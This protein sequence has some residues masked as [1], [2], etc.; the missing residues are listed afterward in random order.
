[1]QKSNQKQGKKITKTEFSAAID[2]VFDGIK[3]REDAIKFFQEI[4]TLDKNEKLTKNY[5]G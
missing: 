4:S 2:K 1:M 5:G 3:T